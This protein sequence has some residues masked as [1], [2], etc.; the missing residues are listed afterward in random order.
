MVTF[1]AYREHIALIY[2]NLRV[3]MRFFTKLLACCVISI[4]T[5]VQAQE[6]I[7]GIDYLA[8]TEN[9]IIAE[10]MLEMESALIQ[11]YQEGEWA[12]STHEDR[13]YALR[14]MATTLKRDRVSVDTYDVINQVAPDVPLKFLALSEEKY[15]N[16]RRFGNIVRLSKE[17]EE[18]KKLYKALHGKEWGT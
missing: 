12:A 1:V 8:L 16:L 9:P 6:S 15:P 7:L 10:A 4:S 5:I 3:K 17:G 2:S 11:Y 14:S 18:S 13:I